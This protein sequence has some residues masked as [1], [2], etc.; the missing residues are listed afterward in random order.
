MRM[1]LLSTEFPPGPG[2]IGTQASQIAQHLHYLG[3][4]IL[5]LSSQDYAPDHEIDAF[6]QS[7]P[8]EVVRFCHMPCV[9]LEAI[10]RWKV[11]DRW[12]QQWRPDVILVTGNRMV[13]LS[14]GIFIR[15]SVPWIAIGHGTEFGT[16]TVFKR[17][18]TQW[19]FN[20][21]SAVV[22]VSQ[23]TRNKMLE[24]GIKPKREQVIPNGADPSQ[25]FPLLEEC[26]KSFRSQWGFGDNPLILT[27]GNVTERK[28]QEVVVRSF[29]TILEEIPNAQY[30]IIGLPTERER[31]EKLADKLG[32]FAH[33]HFLGRVDMQTLIGAYNACDLFVMV[34]RHGKDGRFEGYGIAVVEAALCEKPAVVSRSAG[35][36]EVIIEQQTGYIVP[37]N[38]PHETAKAIITLL[39]NP[40]LRIEMGKNARRR[41]LDKQTWEKSVALYNNI[42]RKVVAEASDIVSI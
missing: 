17:I 33:I 2:G 15:S 40:S 11:I 29:P 41:A 5:V 3:W 31:L 20:R 19:A 7:Q 14:A 24:M 25:F 30:V 34:S 13:W 6:N 38:D 1:M 8:F 22:L 35:L 21:A 28:G 9:L 4:K 23:Y 12:V 42:L 16:A 18:L 10:M 32:V 39:R 37:E 36:V 26:N 27:V